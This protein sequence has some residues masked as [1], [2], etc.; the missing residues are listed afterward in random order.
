MNQS[1]T[2]L[3]FR[4]RISVKDNVMIGVLFRFRVRSLL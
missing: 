4:V 1:P 3:N 2:N